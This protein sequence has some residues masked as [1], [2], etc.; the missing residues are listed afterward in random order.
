[1][2]RLLKFLPVIL[3]KVKFGFSSAEVGN[4]DASTVAVVFSQGVHASNYATG[5]TITVAGAGAT[6]STA[7]RQSNTKV[8]YFALSAPVITGQAVTF[9]YNS[10]PGDYTNLAASEDLPTIPSRNVT[11]NL[12]GSSMAGYAM[13]VLG[14]T[15][16]N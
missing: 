7:T 8:V 14:L 11:N 6:I 10:G 1:M 4:V 16:S 9:A 5:V 12:G 15:Y 2:S 13:G 3:G